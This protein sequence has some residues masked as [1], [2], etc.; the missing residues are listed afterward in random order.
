MVCQ[1]RASESSSLAFEEQSDASRVS[2]GSAD[3]RDGQD[4]GE[5]NSRQSGGNAMPGKIYR[6]KALNYLMLII[7]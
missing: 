6:S 1:L 5:V 2:G 4:L 3:W 7:T